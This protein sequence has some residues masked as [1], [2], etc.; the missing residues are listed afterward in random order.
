MRLRSCGALLEQTDDE[1]RAAVR[2]MLDA[3][4]VYDPPTP[5]DRLLDYRGLTTEEREALDT[6]RFLPRA[7]R[8]ALHRIRG[9]VRGI[10][11]LQARHVYVDA[12]LHPHRRTFLYHHEVAHDVLEWHNALFVITPEWALQPDVRRVFEAEAN[13]FAALSLFQVDDLARW[14]RG[15]RLE[16]K[17]LAALAARYGTS[18]NATA[19]HYVAEQDLPAALVVGSPERTSAGRQQ[20]RLCYG[21]ANGA[22]LRQFGDRLFDAVFPPTSAPAAVVN[23][24]GAPIVEE[25]FD[26][27]D[28]RRERQRMV[29]ET[30][31]NGYDTFTLVHVREPVRRRFGWLPSLGRSAPAAQSLGSGR[32]T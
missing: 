15:R 12:T 3:C 13:R 19:R 7:I 10:L 27:T 14:Q 9:R 22:Y 5:L 28:L 1:I 26:L 17:D 31:Y 30:I 32:A 25:E 20:I 29:A 16:A 24:G 8:R 18:L 4:D 21:V 23:P 2:R 11:D 6:N